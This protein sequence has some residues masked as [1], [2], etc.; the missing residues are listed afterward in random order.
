MLKA[1]RK[2]PLPTVT[3]GEFTLEDLASCDG[4]EGRPAYFTFEEKIYDATQSCLWKEG[5]HIGRHDAGNCL[6]E[7]PSLAP[8]G[9][10]KVTAMAAVGELIAVGSRKVPLHERVFFHGV[11]EPYDC[12]QLLF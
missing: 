1:K 11:H 10:K 4:K 7:A 3:T 5:V 12:L 8:H 2:E 6:T 9:R